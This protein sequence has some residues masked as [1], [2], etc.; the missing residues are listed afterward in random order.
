MRVP[1]VYT[2]KGQRGHH[3]WLIEFSQQLTITEATLGLFDRWLE[4]TGKLGGQR[5]V[6]RLS[7]DRRIIEAMLRFN[8][9]PQQ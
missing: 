5:K 4:S 3:Q 9:A 6:P 8:D 7:N 1:P 2:T